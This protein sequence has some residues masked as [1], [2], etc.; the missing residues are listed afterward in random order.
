[1]TPYMLI[2]CGVEGVRCEERRRR[3]IVNTP[4]SIDEADDALYAALLLVYYALHANIFTS[5]YIGFA[6]HG[7]SN[8]IALDKGTANNAY[9]A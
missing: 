3:R 5:L 8:T 1:M 7:N 9:G 6:A 2:Q 4:R